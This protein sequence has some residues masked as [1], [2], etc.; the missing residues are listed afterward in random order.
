MTH[1]AIR[2][3]GT[4]QVTVDGQPVRG[5]ETEKARALLAHLALEAERPHQRDSLAELL[6]P[7]RS[8]GAARANLRHTLA[9]LRRVIGE[10]AAPLS[11]HGD[12]PPPFLLASRLTLQFNRAS[13]ALVDAQAFVALLRS[14]QSSESPSLASLE[15]A[16]RLYRGPLLEDL[17]V[18]HSADFEEWLLLNREHFRR[19]ALDAMRR[20]GEGYEEAGDFGS[21]LP[22]A[23]RRAEIEP[24]DE[25][26]QRQVMRLLALA[27]QRNAALTQY[28]ACRGILAGEL[29]VTLAAE[30]VELGLRIRAGD[31]ENPRSAAELQAPAHAP[32]FANEGPEEAKPSLFVARERE[33]AN[34]ASFLDQALQGGGRIAF[35]TGGPGQ[36]KT[37][38]LGEFARRAMAADPGLLV[39]Q[40]DCSDIGGVADPYLPFRGVMRMLTGDVESRCL[41]GTIS[42]D[43]ARR[44]WGA[45]PVVMPTL[46][47][48]G[49]GLIGP[50]LAGEPL[51]A[52]ANCTLPGRPD[53]LERLRALVARARIS[54]AGLE[55]TFLFEQYAEVL[56]AVARQQPLLLLL[57]DL[58]WAD[59]ASVGLLFYLGRQ[60][61]AGANRIL[62]VCAYRPEEVALGRGAEPHPLEKVLDEFR[63]TFGDV[64]VDLDTSGQREGRAFVDAFLDSERN[65]LGSKFR[66][67]LFKRTAGHPLFTVEL[68]R[69]M[70]ERGDL[71]RDAG[72]DGAWI[73]GPDLNWDE[74]PP[75]VE[76]VIQ[77]RI[78]RLDPELREMVNYASV[79]GDTFTAQVVA[80]VL[81]TGEKPLLRALQ[82]LERLRL[83]KEVGE[84][85][86]GTGPTARY[87]FS[88]ILIREY[89]YRN[90]S[91][92]ARRLLHGQIARALECLYQER[93]GEIAIQLAHHYYAAA[94]TVQSFRY[95]IMAAENAAR[96]Y[97][98]QEAITLYSRAIALSPELP[99][100][101]VAASELYRGRGRAYET[102][103]D[104]ENARADHEM[105]LRIA[106]TAGESRLE[107]RALLDLAELWT[108]R[109]YSQ[110]RQLIDQALA[111]A[112]AQN[113]PALLAGSLNWVG[114]WYA[115]AENPGVALRYHQEAL[116]IFE[117]SGAAAEQAGTLDRLGLASMLSGDLTAAIRYYDRAVS[118]FRELGDLAG[119]AA[120]LTGR[121]LAG[122]GA[123]LWRT[124]ASPS[125]PANGRL[126]LEE[127]LQIARD[128]AAPS[129]TAW[130]LWSLSVWYTGQGEFGQALKTGH[131][132]VAVAS[133]VGH[134]EWSV[135]TRS[136]LGTLYLELLAPEA[137]RPYLQQAQALVQALRSQH[138]VHYIA[139]GLAA[140]WWLLGEPA[141]ALACL[142][143]VVSPE[144]GMDSLHKRTCWGRRAELALC[145]GDPALALEITNRLILSV[146]GLSPGRVVSYL[147]ELK[148]EALTALG[149]VE[150]AHAVLAA[151][152]E[153]ARASGE[154][155]H[156][157][158][159]HASLGRLCAAANRPLEAGREFD[160]ARELIS[161]LATTV[162]G[163]GLRED[164]LQRAR[165]MVG[166]QYLGARTA[167]SS[168]RS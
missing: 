112:Q 11:A 38:L 69:A 98:N 146:P 132:A 2:L 58:Q 126:D 10:T 74:L 36:G 107:W 134:R 18:T 70:Q 89:L 56:Q 12:T 93:L 22:H 150:D 119:L 50:I 60:I 44:L 85:Q 145:Q 143:T 167:L 101:A 108:S 128:T 77:T 120:S 118:L 129:A 33:L 110:S 158:R 144:L 37:A 1:L 15:E 81:D 117:R 104:F 57:D 19:L 123:Y 113:E 27:G 49:S 55:Q 121:G 103:G 136:V 71:L 99:L 30:T 52:R 156:L 3:L 66:A 8:Q 105:A 159:I 86:A 109:D 32:A 65:R 5:F 13:D 97:A 135:G 6:W 45:Q 114:N 64:W 51:L 151:A 115:N 29:G 40:G 157:W 165:S 46:I 42:R 168:A 47:T 130:A 161:D 9:G 124:V 43:H 54:S 53:W 100:E 138:W 25:D 79:E 116:E 90:L 62:I 20:L 166:A 28:E 14:P 91:H 149:R 160:V 139:A 67:A 7:E 137:A 63:R 35:V 87:Q 152:L 94:N 75:R 41:A 164:F 72:A 23:C 106:R 82:R 163:Q 59:S 148:G 73:V 88:H 31:L 83:I 133:A 92:G 147:W 80:A 154:R 48:G 122:S 39:A 127:A 125:V 142:A 140:T 153:N 111:L 17:S 76:A 16:V 102:L 155:F 26:A 78:G 61:F 24:Y 4:M 34:L 141:Q 84:A 21:A 96:A 68:L 131:E 162:P 95:S